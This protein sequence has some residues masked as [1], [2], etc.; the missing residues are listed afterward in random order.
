MKLRFAV[1]THHWIHIL[2]CTHCTLFWFCLF[3][4]FFFLSH[5]LFFFP[6]HLSTW[7]LEAWSRPFM[8]S[9][10]ATTNY[11]SSRDQSS[12]DTCHLPLLCPGTQYT[13]SLHWLPLTTPLWRWLIAFYLDSFIL[14]LQL[15]YQISLC[16]ILMPFSKSCCPALFWTLHHDSFRVQDPGNW[17]VSAWCLK[18]GER[19][20]PVNRSYCDIIKS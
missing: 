16:S 14:S 12:P 1:K 7:P 8:L 15:A 18:T 11:S 19:V 13:F 10:S 17:M 3:L 2:N 5:E 20:R 6:F 9:A 4:S